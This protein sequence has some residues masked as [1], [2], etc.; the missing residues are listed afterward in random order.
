MKLHHYKKLNSPDDWLWQRHADWD[1]IF[2]SSRTIDWVPFKLAL[3]SSV[4]LGVLKF[5]RDY[6]S[7]FWVISTSL[8]DALN[9]SFSMY[10]INCE[11]CYPVLRLHNICIPGLRFEDG[12]RIWDLKLEWHLQLKSNIKLQDT[13]KS[14]LPTGQIELKKTMI[15]LE[16]VV[17]ASHNPA[18]CCFPIVIEY[19][20]SFKTRYLIVYQ[21]LNY[22]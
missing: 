22:I 17:E 5:K 11:C 21:C 8:R 15:K 19:A 18:H 12:W 14:R 3:L 20:F 1:A 13:C 16:L 6:S 9:Y 4:S 10:G 7:R 2:M